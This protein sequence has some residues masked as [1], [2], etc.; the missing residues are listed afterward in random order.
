LTLLSLVDR[1]GEEPTG[2]GEE[3]TGG[4]GECRNPKGNELFALLTDI[5]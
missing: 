3:P 5:L 1:E 4:R 2:K